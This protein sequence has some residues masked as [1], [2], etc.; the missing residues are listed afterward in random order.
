[1]LNEQEWIENFLNQPLKHVLQNFIEIVEK[2]KPPN[3]ECLIKRRPLID[4]IK[5]LLPYLK[6]SHYLKKTQAKS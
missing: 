6:S 5:K 1:L 2:I 4:K 3:P